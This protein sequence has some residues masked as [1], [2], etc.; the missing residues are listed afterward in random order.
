[1]VCRC[2]AKLRS[3]RRVANRVRK[4]TFP[5]IPELYSLLPAATQRPVKLHQCEQLVTPRLR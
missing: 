4:S 3:L 2:N 1:M 5:M